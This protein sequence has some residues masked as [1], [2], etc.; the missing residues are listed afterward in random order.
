M[1]KK[2]LNWQILPHQSMGLVAMLFALSV[3]LSMGFAV[4][5]FIV[6]ISYL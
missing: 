1:I 3:L 6:K 2:V 5:F 4:I